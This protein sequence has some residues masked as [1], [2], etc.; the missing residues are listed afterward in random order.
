MR[1]ANSVWVIK[2]AFFEEIIESRIIMDE[3][4]GEHA[5]SNSLVFVNS[6]Q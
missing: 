2:K 3:T 1:Q 6:S 5:S 4:Q